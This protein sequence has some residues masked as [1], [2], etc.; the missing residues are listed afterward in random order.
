[1]IA[2][3]FA[4]AGL[5]R[6][7]VLDCSVHALQIGQVIRLF[8]QWIARR[9]RVRYATLCNVH[10]VMEAFRDEKFRRVIASADL[11]LPDGMPLVWLGRRKG[12]SLPKRVYGPDLFIEFCRTTASTGYKH[13]LYGGHEGVPETV[14][15]RLQQQCPGI[16]VVGT[17]SPPFRT[18]S[19]L[20]TAE[21]IGH[22]N[23]SGADVLWVAL[24][25]PK[26]EQWMYDNLH[27]LEVPVIVGIGQAFDIYAKRVRQAP[28]WVMN[29]G[30]EW[31]FR[32]MQEPR[33][34]SRRYLV[35]NTQFV[36]YLALQRLGLLKGNSP[37][38]GK[39]PADN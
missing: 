5:K 25:C 3:D 10:M 2:D 11:R 7:D 38:A 17:F 30:M 37:L 20:A 24:G 34:L 32:L 36:G 28:R 12:F 1:M 27:R 23:R 26:Q 21:Y 31:C 4:S 14:A 8:E 39:M 33:R 18:H 29:M 15:A 16:Q 9:D 22:I 35:Y 6:F 13:F 19:D